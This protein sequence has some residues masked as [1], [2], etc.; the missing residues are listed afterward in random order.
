MV[1][2]PQIKYDPQTAV[3][4]VRFQKLGKLYHFD[5]ADFPTLQAGDFVIVETVRGLQMGEVAGFAERE[6]DNRSYKSILRIATPRDMLLRQQWQAKEVEALINCR[7]T[8]AQLGGYEE[9]KFVKAEYT[10]DGSNLTIMYSTEAAF[11]GTRLRNEL[12]DKYEAAFE[13]RQIGP[14]DV[15]RIMGGQGACGGPRCCSTFLTDFSPVSIKMA[16][17]QG[18][19]LTPTEITG[20]CGRLRCCLVYEYEQ[21]VEARKKLP[22]RNRVV[23]TPYGEGRVKEVY[24]LRDGVDVII[25]NQR[26]FVTR[27]E[28]IPMAEFKALKSKAAA[29]CSRNEGGGCDCGAH[30]PKSPSQ[31]L[32]AAIEM[33]HTPAPSGIVIA[34]PDTE[35][36]E[37]TS[38]T[39]QKPSKKRRWSGRSRKS[40]K[41]KDQQP[42]AEASSSQSQGQQTTEKSEAPKKRR[43][44]R[45]NNRRPRKPNS[46]NE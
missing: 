31:D 37:E 39:S 28:I 5:Y 45:R 33:A 29:G 9:V 20:M 23:G 1:A 24:P 14:R 42:K 21:Y 3:T 16:K 41:N 38:E 17:A 22:Y 12:K 43:S 36:Q 4:G 8:A 44:K 46:T 10:F 7:E 25:E 26:M 18:I 11:K 27:E 15:A 2:I 6:D 34:P 13:F 35:K 32:N 40:N 30:R 19:P